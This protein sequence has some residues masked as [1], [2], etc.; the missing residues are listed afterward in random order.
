MPPPQEGTAGDEA[1]PSPE[2]TRVCQRDL[3]GAAP[4]T[5]GRLRPTHPTSRRPRATAHLPASAQPMTQS[6]P[7]FVSRPTLWNIPPALVRDRGRGHPSK[8]ENT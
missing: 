4:Q 5:Q 3:E 6:L 7:P 1:V 2:I 8:C